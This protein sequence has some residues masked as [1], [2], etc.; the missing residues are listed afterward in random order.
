MGYVHGV[1]WVHKAIN[2]SN[3]LIA[4]KHNDFGP[5]SAYLVGFSGARRVDAGST[6]IDMH[7]FNWRAQL[8]THP[9]RQDRAIEAHV[10]NAW[11]RHQAT[12]M[13]ADLEVPVI[14][15]ANDTALVNFSQYHDIYSLGVVL[16]EVG[17]W[18]PLESFLGQQGQ[19]L[20]QDS[21][22]QGRRRILKD[23]AQQLP[24]LMGNKY[25]EIVRSCLNVERP[26]DASAGQVLAALEG[27]IT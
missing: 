20:L 5:G 16:L 23:L 12:T 25:Y 9:E 19:P 18:R 24:T 8:Y 4:S 27:I 26:Q 11:N 15:E 22:E 1:G 3:I 14:L 10:R 17:L 2:S 13:G 6:G 21:D 7:S